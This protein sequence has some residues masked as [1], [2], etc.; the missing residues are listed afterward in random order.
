M[1]LAQYKVGDRD[2]IWIQLT[3][4]ETCRH[5]AN[6]LLAYLD[7]LKSLGQKLHR[8]CSGESRWIAPMLTAVANFC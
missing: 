1:N 8:A 2:S 6:L 3:L 4:L 5:E 7:V